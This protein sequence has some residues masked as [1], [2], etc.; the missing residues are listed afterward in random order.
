[1]PKFGGGVTVST[2]AV[3]K[4]LFVS[5]FVRELRAIFRDHPL[6]IYSTHSIQCARNTARAIKNNGTSAPTQTNPINNT[7]YC[8]TFDAILVV[9]MV[10]YSINPSVLQIDR[11]RANIPNND[12]RPRDSTI[13]PR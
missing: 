12:P 13:A 7:G 4:V 6:E 11:Q 10:I 5:L 3:K 9:F 8:L 1:M 2:S